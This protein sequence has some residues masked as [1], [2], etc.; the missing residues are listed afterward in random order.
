M[1]NLFKYFFLFFLSSTFLLSQNVASNLS[2]EKLRSIEDMLN[3][4]KTLKARFVQVSLSDKNPA[5]LSGDFYFQKFPK[6]LK[7]KYDPPAPYLVVVDDDLFIYEDFATEKTSFF[8]SESLIPPVFSKKSI[9]LNKD[10]VIQ[11]SWQDGT[12]FYLKIHNEKGGD[13]TFQ[14][15]EN[16]LLKGWETQGFLGDRVKVTLLR[17]E[18]NKPLEKST[19]S[20]KRSPPSKKH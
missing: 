15:S 5:V 14:F 4:I 18:V 9:S 11:K 16:Y 1:P 13:I 8:S 10:L 12:N 7:F 20:Y 6:K 2:S 17:T 3:A 19:F